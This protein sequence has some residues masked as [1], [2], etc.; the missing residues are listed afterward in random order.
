MYVFTRKFQYLPDE[1]KHRKAR[2]VVK[3]CAQRPGDYGETS[4]PTIPLLVLR[5]IWGIGYMLGQ[6]LYQVDIKGAYLNADIDRELY[7]NP[8]RGS[9]HHGK[10]VVF[11]LLKTL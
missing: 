7:M 8:P 6:D 1:A 5:L 3:G 9:K 4:A 10:D 11:K 2:L